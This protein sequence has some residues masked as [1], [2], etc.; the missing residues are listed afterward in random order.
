MPDID[1]QT[2]DGRDDLVLFVWRVG[3][4]DPQQAVEVKL[5]EG[6][7]CED[8]VTEV[9]RVERAAEE[10]D[11]GAGH[12]GSIT[13]FVCHCEEALADEAI[14]SLCGRLLRPDRGSQ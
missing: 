13:L 8:E 6:F 7:G 12:E 1:R 2:L 9:W 4:K 5:R 14:P 3:S 11:L 10:S